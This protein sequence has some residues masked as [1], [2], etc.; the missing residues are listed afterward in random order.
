MRIY[1]FLIGS[2][3]FHLFVILTFNGN[4]KGQG[5]GQTITQP[6]IKVYLAPIKPRI[7]IKNDTETDINDPTNE[8]NQFIWEVNPDQYIE[9]EYQ[10]VEYCIIPV[11][12]R[13]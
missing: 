3:L 6:I 11:G 12:K 8:I 7:F 4:V 13:K 1:Y 9:E 10:K 5:Q 2:L